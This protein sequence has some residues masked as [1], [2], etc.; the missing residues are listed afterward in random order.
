MTSTNV[1]QAE[2]HQRDRSRDH[3]RA[4]GDPGLDAQPREG[5]PRQNAGEESQP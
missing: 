4:D 1:C 5:E 3:R 2:S